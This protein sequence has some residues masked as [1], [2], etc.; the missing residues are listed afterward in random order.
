M[1][2][3][4]ALAKDTKLGLFG[5]V[6]TP[7]RFEEIGGEPALRAI[8]DDFVDRVFDDVMIGFIFHRANKERIKR[9]EYEHAAR[10][11]GADVEYGGRPLD[12]AHAPHRI[13]GGQ[14]LRRKEIL[15]QTLVAHHVPEPIIDA[16]MEHTES[17]RHLI[18]KDEGSTC[19]D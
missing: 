5:G 10:W 3:V 7:S 18:T 16:W 1:L 14:F 19:R 6:S 2:P 11:L 12:V 13:L 9:H 4:R 15:R 8:I 17:L